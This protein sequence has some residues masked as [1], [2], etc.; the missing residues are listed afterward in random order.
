MDYFAQ[1]LKHTDAREGDDGTASINWG[2]DSNRGLVD[3]FVETI[4][5]VRVPETTGEEGI[6]A[7]AVV[8]ATH[9]FVKRGDP[10]D[11]EFP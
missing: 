3:D 5:D 8:E 9:G 7:V 4:R 2:S 6:V 11:V 1:T 10:V